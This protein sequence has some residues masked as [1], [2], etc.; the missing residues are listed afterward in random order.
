MKKSLLITICMAFLFPAI[1]Q[2]MEGSWYGTLNAGMLKLRIV[3]NIT[4]EENGYSATMDSPDQGAKGIKITDIRY[5]QPK[6]T[7][8]IQNAIEYEGL[9]ANDTIAGTFNQNGMDFPL[10]FSRGTVEPTSTTRPQDPKPPFPYHTESI[11]FKNKEA[12]ITLAGTFTRP[13]EG[14]DFPVA[15]LVSGSGPQNRDEEILNHRPFLVLSDYLTRNG[16]AVLRYD[17]R[18]VGDSEGDYK[19]ASLY[20]FTS[21]AKAALDYLKTRKDIDTKKMGVIGHS[22]GGTIALLLASEPQNDLSY[23]V[24]MAGMVMRGDSLLKIQRYLLSS[25]QGVSDQDIAKNEEL[26]NIINNVIKQHPEDYILQ[27]IEHITDECLPD[28]LRNEE[29]IRKVFQQGVKQ[30]MTPEL[31]S[32]MAWDPSEILS[33]IQCNVLAIGGDKDLQVPVTLNLNLLQSQVKKR[34]TTKIYPNLNHLFQHCTTGL[35]N[36]YA[37]INETISPEVL[38]DIATWIIHNNK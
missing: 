34:V 27:N 14:H 38:N 32:L 23:I 31:K 8:N 26:I 17:D 13:Q 28:S 10:V 25:K 30:L 9:Y 11:Q 15:I 37:G 3:L 6:L 16:I 12:G 2:N 36:E 1:S 4:A 7:F 19:T 5:V 29:S 35:P 20:D 21:D 22:E 24:S 18:G 33:K